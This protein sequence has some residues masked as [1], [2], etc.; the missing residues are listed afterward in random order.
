[1]RLQTLVLMLV[2]G[3][4]GLFAAFMVSRTIGVPPA[5]SAEPRPA[6]IVTEKVLVAQ[7]PLARWTALK[8]Y[9]TLFA[10][11]D[12]PKVEL[13]R[14][15]VRSFDQLKEKAKDHLLARAL[16]ADEPL[17]LLH[18]VDKSEAGL[19]HT[20]R[21]GYVAFAVRATA[22]TSAGGFVHPD[23]YVKVFAP[24]RDAKTVRLL[25]QNIRVVAVD[26]HPDLPRDRVAHIPRTITLEVTDEEVKKLQLAQDDGPLSLGLMSLADLQR[27][28]VYQSD[29]RRGE[30]EAP[31]AQRSPQR[32]VVNER[33]VEIITGS[34]LRRYPIGKKPAATAKSPPADKEDP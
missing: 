33:F 20:L 7:K 34:E 5:E 11:K 18:V 30:V 10:I 23:S 27:K 26:T 17:S 31:I 9:E 16:A 32:E 19:Q 2:A 3:A 1:M 8:E 6:L 24:R 15:P 4:C 28:D 25:M 12:V 21:P 14:E 29:N 13:P 22:E